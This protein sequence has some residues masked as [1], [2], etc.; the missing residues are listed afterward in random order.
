MHAVCDP[1]GRQGVGLLTLR[2]I[3][4]DTAAAVAWPAHPPP[5]H[6]TVQQPHSRAYVMVPS[7]TT[8]AAA[9]G[10]QNSDVTH[11]PARTH[12]RAHPMQ[13]KT[14]YVP[15]HP[16]QPPERPILR[17]H[18]AP[19]TTAPM[20][21][22]YYSRHAQAAGTGGAVASSPASK[23]P[24]LVRK[25][26]H[27]AHSVHA[28]HRLQARGT[29]QHRH[30]CLAIS[31]PPCCY[32]VGV[33]GGHGAARSR[34]RQRGLRIQPHKEDHT[35]PPCQQPR[36]RIGPFLS[37]RP[38]NGRRGGHMLGPLS[39]PP[40]FPCGW[41]VVLQCSLLASCIEPCVV[42]VLLSVLIAVR[43]RGLG[44]LPKLPH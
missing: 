43:G 19:A 31:L 23:R 5:P 30:P 25:A 9:E 11:A 37:P 21:C 2:R 44:C 41:L 20:H 8:C 36:V 18:G 39:P 32:I 24:V 29:V 26:W 12:G 4:A 27:M 10:V 38:R 28:A 1:A 3:N 42:G 35:T 40:P 17:K 15:S 6:L 16:R 34:C 33:L 14:S 7:T 13:H 22:A